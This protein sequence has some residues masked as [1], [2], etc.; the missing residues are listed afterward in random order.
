MSFPEGGLLNLLL[1]RIYSKNFLLCVLQPYVKLQ[2]YVRFLA[3]IHKLPRID[4]KIEKL[5]YKCIVHAL[6]DLEIDSKFKLEK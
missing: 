3:F 1:L 6:K 2:F 4:N 5:R